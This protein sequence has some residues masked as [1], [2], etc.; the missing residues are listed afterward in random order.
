MQTST[1]FMPQCRMSCKWNGA[2][3]SGRED[4]D[5]RSEI[6]VLVLVCCPQKSHS[7]PLRRIWVGKAS[8]FAPDRKLKNAFTICAKTWQQFIKRGKLPEEGEFTSPS[9]HQNTPRHPSNSCHTKNGGTDGTFGARFCFLWVSL[10]ASP[11]AE[12]C[13]RIFLQVFADDK[14]CGRFA[15]VKLNHR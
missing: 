5:V 2:R 1:A 6:G 8:Q 14:F 3:W 13:H 11:A 12:F 10:T 7:V 9:L 15:A 4:R